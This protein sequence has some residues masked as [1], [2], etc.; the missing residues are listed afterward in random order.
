MFIFRFYLGLVAL[1]SI[2]AL[3]GC[4]TESGSLALGGGIGAATGAGI[5]AI[6]D[7]GSNGQ[8]RTRNVIIGT[9]V[10]GMA[11]M[12]TGALVH[13]SSD[14]KAKNAYAE[15]QKSGAASAPPR[16]LNPPEL[17]NPKV[18]PRWIDGKVIGNR[19]VDGHWEYVITE[20]A[21]WEGTE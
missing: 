6:A 15:G 11:G 18:E 10:G 9:A 12:M 16:P 21:H 2:S 4:A 5:G 13:E 20:P 8:Y 14:S 17:K 7:P 3:S 1:V 19:Y